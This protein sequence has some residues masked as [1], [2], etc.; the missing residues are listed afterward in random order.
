M[1]VAYYPSGASVDL[2]AEHLDLSPSALPLGDVASAAARICRFA[3]SSP[4][5]IAQHSCLM[6]DAAE[7]RDLRA[8]CLAHDAFSESMTSDVPSTLK[9]QMPALV[10]LEDRI[11][12]AVA[13]RWS[14]H[15]PA[16]PELHDL[17]RRAL[18]SEVEAFFPS[19]LASIE[20]V[21]GYRP[22]VPAA[23]LRPAW[24]RKRARREWL[25]RASG[26]CLT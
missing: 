25:D 18:R 2:S 23:E 24:S 13:A 17:D 7:G 1:F 21:R 10:A 14:M 11:L 12:L 6:H 3:G 15:W 16:P 8:W 22:L 26:L 5:T 4:V 20:G 9:A 19:H